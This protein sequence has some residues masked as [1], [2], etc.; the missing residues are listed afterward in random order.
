MGYMRY[1][2]P[3]AAHAKASIM[4]TANTW[5]IIDYVL[6]FYIDPTIVTIMSMVVKCFYL[7]TKKFAW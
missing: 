3:L 4:S 7:E 2:P 1:S 6:R 5:P